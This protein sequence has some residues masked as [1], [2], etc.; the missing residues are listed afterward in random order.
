ME[1]ILYITVKEARQLVA[2]D[3]GGT[4]DPYVS[5]EYFDKGK[6][7]KH[8]TKVQ[9]K[10]LNPVWNEQVKIRYTTPNEPISFRVSDA[11]TLSSTPIGHLIG[12]NI[13]SFQQLVYQGKSEEWFVLQG[14]NTGT[15]NLQFYFDP[16]LSSGAAQAST[17]F[18]NA[19]G[20]AP[21]TS[22]V[23]S[24]SSASEAFRNLEVS[25]QPAVHLLMEVTGSN[26]FEVMSRDVSLS[27]TTFVAGNTLDCA[28]VAHIADPFVDLRSV[29]VSFKGSTV[30]QGQKKTKLVTTVFNI[31]TEGQ[32]LHLER[33]KHSFPFSFLIPS[34]CPTSGSSGSHSTNYTFSIEADIINKE[35]FRSSASIN[36]LNLKDTPYGRQ[37]RGITES[38]QTKTLTGKTVAMT[39]SLGKDFYQPLED[40]E[41]KLD[42]KN[43]FS[44]KLEKAEVIL[45][46]KTK[47]GREDTVNVK[48]K[49]VRFFH[50]VREGTSQSNVCIFEMPSSL[51]KS[52][53]SG[54]SYLEYKIKVVID[55]PN[56]IDLQVSVP[57]TVVL[58]EPKPTAIKRGSAYIS[59]DVSSWDVLQ[60]QN[61]AFQNGFSS[62][63]LEIGT[64]KV[65]GKELIWF[66]TNGR[67]NNL[68]ALCTKEPELGP[69]FAKAAEQI[70]NI[71]LTHLLTPLEKFL[72]SHRLEHHYEA[73]KKE[74]V[75]YDLLPYI[76]EAELRQI[77]PLG[78][79]KKLVLAFQNQ[80]K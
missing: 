36:I 42:V 3:S 28:I 38:G 31:V 52:F 4:S 66:V 73:L 67:E 74:E 35:D 49:N 64:L 76:T 45:V 60:T 29:Y 8:K 7:K 12:M 61:W 56:A 55:I 70:V 9:K 27:A 19:T 78:A 17:P 80:S 41:I 69:S 48:T 26:T 53:N 44:K 37:I 18:L 71:S 21:M 39:V 34:H 2:A 65:T 25:F 33:G 54:N 47:E 63:S 5:V 59:P 72:K 11:D 20:S 32:K 10:T 62:A 1:Q 40:V 79:A 14:V 58:P 13:A 75:T 30:V 77:L 46:R 6:D 57:I 22:M 24:G 16:P 23:S 50:P 51:E 43:E 68:Q 15:L